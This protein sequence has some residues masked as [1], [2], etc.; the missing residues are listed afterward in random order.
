MSNKVKAET[1]TPDPIVVI[2]VPAAGL[3]IKRYSS[4]VAVLTALRPGTTPDMGKVNKAIRA[5]LAN[6]PHVVAHLD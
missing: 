4:G 5:Y 2:D 3:R 6:L 1:P